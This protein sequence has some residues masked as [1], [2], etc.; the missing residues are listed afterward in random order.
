M[1]SVLSN[2]MVVSMFLLF[3]NSVALKAEQSMFDWL[4]NC[5]ILKHF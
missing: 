1:A 5:A 4:I 3:A 2:R